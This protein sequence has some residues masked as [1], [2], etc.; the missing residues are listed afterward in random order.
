MRVPHICPRCQ[1]NW[2]PDNQHPGEYP[3][4]MSRADN[5]TEICSPCGEREAMQTYE[6]GECT[7]TAEW[8]VQL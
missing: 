3:G 7:P 6:R 5:R 2:I 4:A 8:P 1:D